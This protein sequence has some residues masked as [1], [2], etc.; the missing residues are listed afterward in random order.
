[1]Q[2]CGTVV[3]FSVVI[4]DKICIK[5]NQ[6]SAFLLSKTNLI[7]KVSGSSTSLCPGRVEAWCQARSR[8]YQREYRPEDADQ[9][10][11]AHSPPEGSHGLDQSN[12]LAK[13][14]AQSEGIMMAGT[15]MGC[16]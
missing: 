8:S 14:Q 12:S 15:S 6:V 4:I 13:T 1:M 2:Y 9:V 3:A 7:I 10:F 5:K 16:G 11:V